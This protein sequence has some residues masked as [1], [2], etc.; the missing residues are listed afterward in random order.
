MGAP[1]LLDNNGDAVFIYT[2]P[3]LRSRSVTKARDPQHASKMFK[4]ARKDKTG[5]WRAYHFTSKANPHI[6]EEGLAEISEDMTALAYRQEILA[7]DIDEVPGALWSRALLDKCRVAP[8][9]V[10]DLVR[11]VVA[12]DPSGCLLYTSP[13]PRD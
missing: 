2:P 6:S 4:K 5:R 11:I 13:S 1:M 7:E 10:P 9:D 3:S 12:V 8:E